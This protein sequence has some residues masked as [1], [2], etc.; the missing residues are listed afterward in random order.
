MLLK[1]MTEAPATAVPPTVD[2]ALQLFV[3]G[4]LGWAPGT[5]SW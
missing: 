5:S 1:E 4:R 2:L 3:P